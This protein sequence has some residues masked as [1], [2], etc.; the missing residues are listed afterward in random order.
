MRAPDPQFALD[1]NGPIRGTEL[2]GKHAIQLDDLALLLHFDGGHPYETNYRGEFNAIPMGR[3]PSV[4]SGSVIFRPGK[5]YKCAVF[6]RVRTNLLP[7]PSFETNSTG[8]TVFNGAGGDLGNTRV[9]DEFYIGGVSARLD[10]TAI[11]GSAFYTSPNP[12][13]SAVATGYSFGVWLRAAAPISMRLEIGRGDGAFTQ[14]GTKVISVTEEWQYYSVST[15]TT[16]VAAAPL[17]CLIIAISTAGT[18]WVDGAQLEQA[19]TPSWPFDGSFTLSASG[20]SN[21][22]WS[23]PAHASTSSTRAWTA[24]YATLW[25]TWSLTA[26]R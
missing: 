19:A 3:A 10:W 22:T 21:Y 12:V 18:L 7:N 20:S 26:G 16:P 8:W 11:N 4:N 25:Q 2:V 15:T 6:G 14:Y 5:F 17:R 13:T 24:C 23:V 9:G 1:V